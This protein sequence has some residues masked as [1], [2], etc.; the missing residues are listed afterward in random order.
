MPPPP[1]LRHWS[2][3]GGAREDHVPFLK[4]LN[5]KINIFNIYDATRIVRGYIFHYNGK[6]ERGYFPYFFSIY[7]DPLLLQLRNLD[8]DCHLNG[9]YMQERP[10]DL[11]GGGPRIF[12]FQIWKIA[13]RYMRCYRGVRGHAPPRKFF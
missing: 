1:S 4:N 2:W 7:I 9:V 13:C 12:F 8:Y 10:Q 3:G 11:A 6:T 5:F